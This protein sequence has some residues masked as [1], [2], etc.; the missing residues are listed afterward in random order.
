VRRRVFLKLLVLI[1]VVVGVSTA[2]LY[3]LVR[4]SWEGSLFDQVQRDLQDKVAIFASV[5]NHEAGTVPF[6]ELAKEMAATAHARATIIDRS[7]KVLADSEANAA[8]MENHANR[9][10]FIAA[11][12][13]QSGGSSRISRTL[14]IE[15][16]YIASPTDF[17]AV[18]LAYPLAEI[19]ANTG[20]VQAKLL[21]AAGIS[22]LVGFIVAWI[23]AESISRRLRRMV[24]FAQ[25]IAAGNL[26]ARLPETGSDE[27]AILS[28]AL[29][30]TAASMERSFRNLESSRQQLETLLNSM[31][32]AVVAVSPE[33]EIAW[34]NGAMKR[35]SASTVA[36]GTPLIRAVRDPDF[37][38]VVAD[39]L[40]KQKTQTV[41]L[42][43]V[44]PGHTFGMTSAPLPDGGA[45]CVLRDNTDIV[46]VERTRRDFIANVSHEL[47]T[48]LT[49]LLG[50][51]ETLLDE[52]LDTKS[53]EFLEIIRRSAQRMSRL[54]DD[55]LT[56]ARVESGEDPL[57]PAPVSAHDLLRDA[58]IAFNE[59]ARSKGLSVDLAHAPDIPVYADRDAVHQVFTN[60]IDNALKYASGTKRIEIGA[61]ERAAD[62]EF[63]VRDFGPG[64]PSEHLPR[65]F[66]RFYRV[67]KARSR[68]AGGTGLGLAIVK[69]IVLNHG[70]Q[71]GV[72]SSLGHGA[73]FWF[74]LPLADVKAEVSAEAGTKSR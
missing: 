60:L 34:F 27:I 10:E 69:H 31:E 59:A 61:A 14:G 38:R 63:Y 16:L 44:V 4:R 28:T 24:S 49:S 37:L 19:S 11:L 73:R 53:H 65:L 2:A 47:R 72:T 45:V 6:Q 5:A 62:I 22:L 9:T 54:T 55:L 23:A 36:V 42:Y 7:G 3:L 39:V 12:K 74:R 15:F 32:D 21:E 66:E 58:Q 46:R 41:T 33:R 17:G 68:E 71:I 8:E 56:L 35:M 48:P 18:R 25:E 57:E 1:V 26:A 40:E 51:T 64:I 20:R 70:G 29:D 30:K 43:S 52:P 50:Y 13:G 67:D